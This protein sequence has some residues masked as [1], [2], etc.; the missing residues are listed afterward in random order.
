[1]DA[2]FKYKGMSVEGEYYCRWLTDYIG[3]NTGGIPDINDNGYQMQTSAMA[4]P[5]VLQLYVGSFADFRQLRRPIGVACGPE[6]VLLKER[7][8]SRQRRV[9]V[10][11]TRARSV[12]RRTRSG[13]RERQRLPP[14]SR[15]E[16]L[17]DRHLVQRS[18]T[19][20]TL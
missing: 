18:P 8:D 20:T 7:G 9:H 6:L 5:K 17:I 1:M 4:V 16:L 14:Q 12:T 13:W 19:A 11:S 3:V 10:M 2:G 15:D